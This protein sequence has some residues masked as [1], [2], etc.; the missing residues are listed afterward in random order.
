MQKA[1]RVLMFSKD[2]TQ[3]ELAKEIGISERC[4]VR[5][6]RGEAEFT[7]TEVY[8]ICRV[9]GIENPLDVFVAKY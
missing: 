3:K 1:L 5:R 9:L 8:N 6:M 7:F 4:M 2:I